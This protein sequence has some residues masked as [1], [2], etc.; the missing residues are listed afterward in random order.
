MSDGRVRTAPAN[1][2]SGVRSLVVNDVAMAP[3]A[4]RAN[5]LNCPAGIVIWNDRRYGM[6]AGISARSI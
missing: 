1:A 3:S 5:A 4:W 6:P 2:P